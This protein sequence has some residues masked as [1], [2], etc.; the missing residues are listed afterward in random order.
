MIKM[1]AQII[2]MM[3]KWYIES[4]QIYGIWI[5]NPKL[6]PINALEPVNIQS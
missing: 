4:M 2:K 6:V 1:K 3:H 5:G